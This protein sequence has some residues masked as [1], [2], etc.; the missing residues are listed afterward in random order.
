MRRRIEAAL[1]KLRPTLVADGGDVE[2]VDYRDGVAFLR[3]LGA[4]GG[5]QHATT[6]LRNHLEKNLLQMVPRLREVRRV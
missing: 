2:L 6:T 1:D 4:C 5:C 3:L